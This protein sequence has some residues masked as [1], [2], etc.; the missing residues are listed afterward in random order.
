MKTPYTIP[1]ALLIAAVYL[2]PA[3]A[4]AK[5]PTEAFQV[6]F[7]YNAKAPAET[8]YADLQRTASRACNNLGATSVQMRHVN[9]ACAKRVVDAGVKQLGRTDIAM[10][11]NGGRSGLVTAAR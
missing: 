6:K 3:S 10:L 8:I 9:R 1:V 7:S 4:H 11:H 5:P 2:A